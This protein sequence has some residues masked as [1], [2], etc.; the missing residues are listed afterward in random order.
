MNVQNLRDNSPQLISYM[1]N[2]GYSKT[3]VERFKRESKGSA[4]LGCGFENHPP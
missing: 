2:N 4:P 3:Y 1:E